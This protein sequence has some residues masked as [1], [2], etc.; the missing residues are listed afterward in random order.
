MGQEGSPWDFVPLASGVL[1]MMPTDPDVRLLLA[2]AYAKLGLKTAA[3]EQV[4]ALPAE[5]IEHPSVLETGRM[6]A[7]MSDDAVAIGT[8]EVTLRANLD[9]LATRARAPID[10]R[11]HIDAWKARAA[12]R[13]HFRCASGAV[14]WREPPK[15]GETLPTWTRFGDIAAKL[16]AARLPYDEVG[17]SVGENGYPAPAL[18]EGAEPPELLVRVLRATLPRGDGYRALVT[19]VQADPLQ[20]CDGLMQVDL[21][22][23]LRDDRVRVLVGDDATVHARA[24][25]LRGVLAGERPI[26]ISLT[27]PTCQPRLS[28]TPAEIIAECER[29]YAS[30][31]AET[32]SRV[33]ARYAGRDRAWWAKRYAEHSERPLS[34]LLVTSRYTTYVRHAI[35]DLAEAMAASGCRVRVLS[36]PTEHATFDPLA[37]RRA[38]ESCEPDLVVIANFPR[39]A[40]AAAVPGNVPYVMW[41][42]DLMPHQQSRAV[43][44][45]MGPLDF[46]VGHLREEMFQ[47]WLYPRARSLA[48][49]MC[50]SSRKFHEGA[51][52]AEQRSRYA[53]EVAY[54]SHHAETPEELHERKMY[55]AAGSPGLPAALTGLFPRI[56]HAAERP[57]AAGSIGPHLHGLVRDALTTAKLASDDRSVAMLTGVY[58]YPIADRVIRHQT[59]RWAAD[60]CREKGWRLHLY[61]RGWASHPTLN[62]HARGELPHDDELRAAYQA[63]RA[64]LH[65]SAHTA[66]HQRVF[67]CAL[68][69][70]LAFC[71]LIADDLTLMEYRAAASACRAGAASRVDDAAILP[72]GHRMHEFDAGLPQVVEYAALCERLGLARPRAVRLNGIHIERLR[73]SPDEAIDGDGL[74]LTDLFPD[75]AEVMFHDRDGLECLLTRAVEDDAWRAAVRMGVARRAEE[76]ATTASL[77]SRMFECITSRLADVSGGDGRR[78]YDGVPPGERIAGRTR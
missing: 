42:Q 50:V 32:T 65:V 21:S 10:L 23:A 5:V 3:N 56:V 17:A 78:W 54:V 57:V 2:R 44:E 30:E 53:C 12:T 20:F 77:V 60:I 52:T 69:G 37:C 76:R 74:A 1:C 63:A 28:P 15:D 64:H 25:L 24:D 58:A 47:Q 48:V 33:E 59:L 70:G 75:P 7:A 72:G 73:S 49:P 22:A 67:E 41:L 26:G 29:A 51:A 34:V 46:V 71:R 11:R 38:I 6:V 62:E 43:G 35:A 40:L 55:E 66:V 45:A 39:S 31:L 8:L 61:G 19:V 36:E 16:A 27:L 13:Q 68:S 4:R 9:A 18:I 14:I